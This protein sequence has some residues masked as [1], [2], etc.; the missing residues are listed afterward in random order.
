MAGISA[1]ALLGGDDEKEKKKK[2]KESKVRW[3]CPFKLGVGMS[4]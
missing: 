2:K 1:F 4:I 3:V